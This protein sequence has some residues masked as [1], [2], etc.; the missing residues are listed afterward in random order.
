MAAK[1]AHELTAERLF[2][3]KWKP[4]LLDRV[5]ERLEAEMAKAGK[6]PAARRLEAGFLAAAEPAPYARIAAELGVSQGYLASYRRALAA[7][8]LP[9]TSFGTKS[10]APWTTLPTSKRK[11]RHCFVPW[12]T[13]HKRLVPAPRPRPACWFPDGQ[14]VA[15]EAPA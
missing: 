9:A 4:T 11:S 8:V 6:S 1:P 15:N 13:G 3:K 14:L 10:P 12:D 7:P 5:I 2:E